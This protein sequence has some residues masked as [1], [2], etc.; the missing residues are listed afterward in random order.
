MNGDMRIVAIGAV[1]AFLDNCDVGGN[2]FDKSQK[3]IAIL[4]S[5]EEKFTS[6]NSAMVPCPHFLC[7]ADCV[8]QDERSGAKITCSDAGPCVF[9]ARHQ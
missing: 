8:W 7:L 5:L 6:T 1:S 4:E 9:R 3:L 2:L